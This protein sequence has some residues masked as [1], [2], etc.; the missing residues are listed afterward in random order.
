MWKPLVPRG[1]KICRYKDIT[2]CKICCSLWKITFSFL[3]S[4]IQG[5]WL[6]FQWTGKKKK[7]NFQKKISQ[8]SFV[9]CK[10]SKSRSWSTAKWLFFPFSQLEWVSALTLEGK[11]LPM[12]Q[13]NAKT[14]TWKQK[15]PS[16]SAWT[17]L[18][19]RMSQP[20]SLYNRT[21]F[22]D[23]F[24]THIHDVAHT[25]LRFAFSRFWRRQPIFQAAD[26]HIKKK[27]ST[28][29]CICCLASWL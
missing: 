14:Q 28:S 3:F 25:L 13:T 7:L 8:L 15:V 16:Y 19:Q 11:R 10:Q 23:A 21:V 20:E 17:V 1:H 22:L 6:N 18:P 4:H 24:L 2:I 9:P 27:K 26:L 12:N 29:T 5:S